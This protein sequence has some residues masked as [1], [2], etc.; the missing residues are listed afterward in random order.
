MVSLT[1]LTLI[2]GSISIAL[3]GPT[4]AA[5]TPD[6]KIAVQM[7]TPRSLRCR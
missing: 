7:S 1:G 2:L 3:A 4:T 6:N 5:S